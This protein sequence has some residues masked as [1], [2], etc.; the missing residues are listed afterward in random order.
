MRLFVSARD[1]KSA[2]ARACDGGKQAGD[3]ELPHGANTEFGFRTFKTAAAGEVSRPYERRE[4]SAVH[5]RSTFRR[6][7]ARPD[8]AWVWLAGM[9]SIHLAIVYPSQADLLLGDEQSRADRGGRAG[10][11]STPKIG[12]SSAGPRRGHTAPVKGF[13]PGRAR[14]GAQVQTRIGS[15]DFLGY[16]PRPAKGTGLSAAKVAELVDALDLGSSGQP[17]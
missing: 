8:A 6:L 3:S 10:C 4:R 12:S 1:R 7:S 14:S 17:P 15:S 2:Q 9:L 13:K 5:F 11:R 16:T